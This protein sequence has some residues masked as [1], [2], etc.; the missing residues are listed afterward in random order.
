MLP[1]LR[2]HHA[3]PGRLHLEGRTTRVAIETAR[4]QVA[5]LLGARPREVVFTSGGTEAV[6]SAIWGAVRRT[7]VDRRHVVTTAVEHSCVLDACAREDADVT[8]VG[9]D[10]LGRFDPAEVTAAIRPDTALVT[11]QLANHE[12]GTMQP[13]AAVCAATRERGVLVHVDAC[14]AVG[15]VPVTFPAIGAD[16]LS[17]TAHKSGGPKGVGVLLVRRGLRIPPL[18]VGGAQERDRRGGLE[19]I[20]AIVGFGAVAELLSGT[21]LDRETRVARARTDRLVA[22]TLSSVPGV[23]RLGDPEL[24]VPHLV[25]LGVDGVEAEP[26]LLGLDQAGVSIHSGSACS[27]ETLEPSPVLAAMG[28]DADRSLRVSV[29]WATVDAD[30]DAFLTAFPVVVARMRSLRA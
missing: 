8:I 21:A 14:A 23:F 25:C 6:N 5:T 19:N 4:E 7:H 12:V 20:P 13:A 30:I 16:L 27:S 3:D 29:G 28:A 9:V 22:E 26:I 17:V 1:F 24:R 10:A 11:V 18:I 15:Q 2:E